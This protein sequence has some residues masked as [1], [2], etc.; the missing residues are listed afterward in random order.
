MLVSFEKMES[1]TVL[2]LIQITVILNI[3]GFSCI[4]LEISNSIFQKG[5]KVR[6]ETKNN[7]SF[8]TNTHCIVY[9][10]HIILLISSYNIKIHVF[11]TVKYI[12]NEKKR[13]NYKK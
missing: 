7:F 8:D 12:Y 9:I 6:N 10:V 11:V 3:R 13:K 2:I 1:L 5:K 4:F